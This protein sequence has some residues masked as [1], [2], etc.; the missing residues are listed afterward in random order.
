MLPA[1]VRCVVVGMGALGSAAAFRLARRLGDEVLVLEQFAPGHTRGA[2]EDHSRIIRH[3]YASTIYTRLTPAMFAA[4][5]EVEDESGTQL[6][7]TTGG[8]DIGDP[9]VPGSVEA[10]ENNAAALGAEG[11]PF[12]ALDGDAVRERWPQW[13]LPDDVRVVFQPDSGSLDIGRAC[14]AHLSLARDSG[15]RLCPGVRVVRVQPAA[16]GG[17]VLVHTDAGVVVEAEDLVLCAGK[18]TNRLLGGLA[19]AA[20]DLHAR[21]GHLLHAAPARGLRP[22]A[23]PDLDPSR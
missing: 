10:I 15:A 21:A 14:A 11:L 12:E 20:L 1:R 3:S 17:S 2:S 18:W 16:D 22:R 19:A 9:A 6:I 7:T 23:V 13:R 8:L 5:R 4:W